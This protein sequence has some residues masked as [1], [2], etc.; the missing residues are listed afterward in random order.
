MTKNTVFRVYED[1]ETMLKVYNR[2]LRMAQV[3]YEKREPGYKQ[4]LAR[5]QNEPTEDQLT[6][7]GL[8]VNVTQGIGTIDTMFSSLTAVDVEF[9]LRRKGKATA[10]QLLAA[11]GGLNQAMKDTKMQRRAKKAIKDAL[12]VDIGWAKVYY[13]YAED[14]EVRDRPA[15]AVRAEVA[16]LLGKDPDMDTATLEKMV[17][18]TEE[19]PIILRD[20]VCVDY[21]PFTDIRYDVS[22]KQIE[23]ARWVAQLTKLP[24]EEVRFNP[25]Y[26]EFVLERY[27]KTEGQRKLDELEGDTNVSGGMDYADVEGL[28][29]NEDTADDMRVTVIEMWDLETGLVT[30]YPKNKVDLILHQRPNPLM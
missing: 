24:A 15:A 19:V 22:A 3:D 23:D 11:E 2:R 16:E 9:I 14:T 21:V 10:E 26:V 30:V 13:D 5:Y 4:F 18:M 29:A 28:G 7:D 12:I 8:R 27:G 1:E 17:A 20:R 6:P 25:Q